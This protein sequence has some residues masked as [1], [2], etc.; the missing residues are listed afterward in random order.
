VA[1]KALGKGIE[2]LIPTTAQKDS[3]EPLLTLPVKLIADNPYQPRKVTGQEVAELTASIKEH[4]VL[5]PI[6]VR[7]HGSGYQ[8]V[9]GSRRLKAS[10]LAGLTDVPVVIKEVTEKQM[11]ALALVENLQRENLN[12]IES[13]LAYK[14]LSEE[15][16]MTQE[17]IAKIVAK[18]RSTVANTMRLLSL[19]RKARLF[20]EEGK[21]SEGH[22]RAML[23]ISSVSL[24]EKICDRIV[25]EGLTV[26]AVE[27]IAQSSNKI[28]MPERRKQYDG[29]K[30]STEEFLA[31]KLGVKVKLVRSGKGGRLELLFS[32]ES[33]LSRL[34]EWFKTR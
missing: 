29:I 26:R 25:S 14:Q 11:L 15:F 30:A 16:G 19:P 28:N 22:A 32:D 17:E 1:R 2:A 33:E 34:V 23:S 9:A 24:I 21:I 12:P 10:R 8:L 13:A 6:V 7:R 4:G 18:D 5:Q 20:I 27:K 31:E 3:K